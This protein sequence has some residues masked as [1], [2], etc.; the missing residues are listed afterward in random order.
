MNVTAIFPSVINDNFTLVFH[1][2]YYDHLTY[3]DHVHIRVFE[4]FFKINV[5]NTKIG[6]YNLYTFQIIP[7]C[8]CVSAQTKLQSCCSTTRA[9]FCL[10]AF[11]HL[12]NL[13]VCLEICCTSLSARNNLLASQIPPLKQ[14]L[15]DK[16]H[17]N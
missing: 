1:Q 8:Y 3:V 15:C 12:T 14:A 5:Q 6:L 4:D 13:A 10:T 9:G 17:V 7:I 16:V 11:S 2:N